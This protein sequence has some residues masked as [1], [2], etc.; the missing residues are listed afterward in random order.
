MARFAVLFVGVT[1]QLLQVKMQK[2]KEFLVFAHAD[3]IF[4]QPEWI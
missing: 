2:K 1:A 3:S 4:H